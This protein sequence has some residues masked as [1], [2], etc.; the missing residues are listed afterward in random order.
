MHQRKAP[1]SRLAV[2]ASKFIS[3]LAL[4]ALLTPHGDDLCRNLRSLQAVRP[5]VRHHHE[6]RNGSGYPDGLRGDAIPLLAQI[7]SV[8]DL[9]DT[10]THTSPYQPAQSLEE[11]IDILRRQAAEGLREPLIVDTFATIVT[12]ERSRSSEAQPH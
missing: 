8:V 9:Y 3:I 5:I 12:R 11:A 7:V 10:V 4:I 1:A 6:Q 2:P